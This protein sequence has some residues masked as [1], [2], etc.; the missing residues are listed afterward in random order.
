VTNFFEEFDAFFEG[1][2]PRAVEMWKW[3]LAEEYEHREVAHDVFQALYG[4]N[5]ITGYLWRI[6][7]FVYAVRHIR[8]HGKRLSRHLIEL[9]RRDMT[10][11]E[12]E[13]SRERVRQINAATG[14]RAREHLK[15]IL[16][17]WYKPKSRPPPKGYDELL[18]QIEA[19]RI[20]S[21]A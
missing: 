8:A 17:P 14:R 19:G 6:Y 1:A 21:A 12:V 16:S 4:A 9:D 2:D 15:V 3:H 18:A 11:D 10:P 13:A 20:A 7:G 5:P